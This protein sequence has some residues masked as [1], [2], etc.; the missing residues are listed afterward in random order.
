MLP[1]QE[2][3]GRFVIQDIKT[4]TYLRH[5]G[6]DLDHPYDDVDAVDEATVWRT[7]EHVSYVL[8]WY[9]DMY[10]SYRI[11]NLDTAEHF[12]KDKNRGIPHIMAELL[13][14]QGGGKGE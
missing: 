4:G 1:K 6:T 5:D 14:P 9:V 8:W 7:L 3:P 2:T 13:Q 10:R 12:V 11:I